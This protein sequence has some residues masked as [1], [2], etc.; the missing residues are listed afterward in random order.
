MEVGK[1][2]SGISRFISTPERLEGPELADLLVAEDDC[3]ALD[4]D[5]ASA[6]RANT[7]LP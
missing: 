5:W 6:S 7:S 4:L 1:D 3:F 2:K